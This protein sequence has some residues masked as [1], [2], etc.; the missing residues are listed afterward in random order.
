M[1]LM[2]FGLPLL[3]SDT[4]ESWAGADS[5]AENIY[6]PNAKKTDMSFLQPIELAGMALGT[7]F[8]CRSDLMSNAMT[9]FEEKTDLWSI[10]SNSGVVILTV[11][12]GTVL[13]G[14]ATAVA[15][16]PMDL[17]YEGVK[18]KGYSDGTRASMVISGALLMGAGGY[19]G[20]LV[21]NQSP[22]QYG[23]EIII[24]ARAGAIVGSYLGEQ[25]GNLIFGLPK[26]TRDY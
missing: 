23:E 24:G 10:I 19:I 14:V 20:Y 26:K 22:Q 15:F 7:Y 17:E 8:A 18:D 13:G 1:A 21:G 16:G 25:L 12:A 4:T 2:L 3:A 9:S 6:S 5:G 11:F